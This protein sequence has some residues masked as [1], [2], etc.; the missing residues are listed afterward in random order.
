MTIPMPSGLRRRASATVSRLS[1]RSFLRS[2][3]TLKGSLVI[4][5]FSILKSHAKQTFIQHGAW[6]LRARAR[7][8]ALEPCCLG[9]YFHDS[10]SPGKTV[11]GRGTLTCNRQQRGCDSCLRRENATASKSGQK[12][13]RSIMVQTGTTF[14]SSGGAT[15]VRWRVLGAMRIA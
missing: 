10:A 4:S 2:C 1:A 5:Y 7:P 11:L 6:H 15:M 14:S 12:L 3:G 9:W 13:R 8:C